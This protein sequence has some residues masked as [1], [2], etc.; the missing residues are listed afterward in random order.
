VLKKNIIVVIRKKSRKKKKL[1]NLKKE[2]KNL[3]MNQ[4]KRNIINLNNQEIKL[5]TKAT[6]KKK[7]RALQFLIQ[8]RV[9]LVKFMMV[10]NKVK[11]EINQMHKDKKI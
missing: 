2:A 7:K 9:Y 6:P 4:G 1:N 8:Q 10:F 11:K 5:K 3:L